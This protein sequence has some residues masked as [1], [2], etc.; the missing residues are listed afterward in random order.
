MQ[1]GLQK[2]VESGLSC[3]R[4]VGGLPRSRCQGPGPREGSELY[5]GPTATPDR[6]KEQREMGLALGSYFSP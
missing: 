1:Q 4:L 3:G 2:L 6:R 5:G